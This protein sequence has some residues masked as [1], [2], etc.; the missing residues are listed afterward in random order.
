[1][2]TLSKILFAAVLSMLLMVAVPFFQLIKSG[3]YRQEAALTVVETR[4]IHEV[5]RPREKPKKPIKPLDLQR[6]RSTDKRTQAF[7]RF[8]LDLSSAA[9]ESENAV[10]VARAGTGAYKTWEVD[11]RAQEKRVVIPQYP[12]AAQ[13]KE[14]EGRVVV[15]ITVNE[16]GTVEQVSVIE[17]APTGLG[18]GVSAA[19]A[20]RQWEFEPALISGVPVKYTFRRPVEFKLN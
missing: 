16:R 8:A 13:E 10:S 4:L 14:I 17:E 9:F 7:G 18:F 20:A 19:E 15:E 3:W 5:A 1:V 6:P 11:V 12:R 2:K